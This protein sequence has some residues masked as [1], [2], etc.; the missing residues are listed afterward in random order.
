MHYHR[1]NNSDGCDFQ[2]WLIS[3]PHKTKRGIAYHFDN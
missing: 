3:I 2:P 1:Q